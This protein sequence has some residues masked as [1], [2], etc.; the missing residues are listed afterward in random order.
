MNAR[1][2][3]VLATVG[4][5]SIAFAGAASA[6]TVSSQTAPIMEMTTDTPFQITTPDRVDTPIGTLEFFDGVPIGDTKEKIFD[7]MDRARA[8]QVF[9]NMIP[10]VSMY[11]LRRAQHEMGATESHQILI[12]ANL[13]DSKTRWLTPN[14]TALYTLG[15]FDLKKDGPTV[16]EVPPDVLGMWDDMYMRWIGDIGMAGPDKGKGGMYLLLPPGYDGPVPDGYHVYRSKT[17]T[18]WNFLRGYVRTSVEDAADNIMNNLKVYPLSQK[19]NPPEMVFKNM[20]GV[21]G[22]NTVP[23]NDFSFFESLDAIIQEEP[24]D[25]IDPE[26]RGLIAAIGIIKG[27]VFNPDQ[28][29]RR[30]LTEGVALGNAYARANT[31]YPRD[32]GAYI[33]KDTDS[34]WVMGYADKDTYFIEDGARRYDA[35]LWLHY[36]AICVTPSM[37][38][39]KPGLGSDY[40]IAD[41]DGDHRP[42]YGSKTY[43]LHLPPNVPVKDNWS[44]TIYDTQTR[45]MLQTDQ[46]FA[47]INSYGEGPKKNPDGSIDIYFAP[48]APKG[49]EKNWIQTIPGKSWFIILRLYGPLEPWLDQTWRPSELE[50][51]E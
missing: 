51:V 21:E 38:V 34:E 7:Y 39:T 18:V 46:Q 44:V 25:F 28:R 11:T 49:W 5:L 31:T 41:M 47:G 12:W 10:A 37:A 33:Y 40:G 2:A 16:I 32:P 6:Q 13:M 24:I 9:V 30:I 29:M 42:L 45:S 48:K 35:R 14:N 26:T 36:N 19:D 17:Y 50:L 43:K 4:L 8:A 20:S 1:K 22:Y 23:P 3:L 27:Q 15:F